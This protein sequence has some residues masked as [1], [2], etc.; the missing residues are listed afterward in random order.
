V[1]ETVQFL[2]SLGDFLFQWFY[3]TWVHA[4]ESPN[5]SNNN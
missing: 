4:V 3:L 1:C 5:M 2:I